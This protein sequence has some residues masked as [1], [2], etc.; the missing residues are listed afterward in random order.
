VNIDIPSGSAFSADVSSR[1]GNIDSDF[2]ELHTTSRNAD[3]DL[4]GQVGTGGPNIKVESRF[5][6]VRFT[7]RG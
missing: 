3:H 5:G 4:N 2:N 7:K 6:Q 1:Y